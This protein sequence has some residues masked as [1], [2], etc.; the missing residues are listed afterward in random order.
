VASEARHRFGRITR[1]CANP[2]AP[3]PPKRQLALTPGTNL[4]ANS[5]EKNINMKNNTITNWAALLLTFSGMAASP[6]TVSAQPSRY[7]NNTDYGAEAGAVY[8]ATSGAYAAL[9]VTGSLGRYSG[10]GITLSATYN[11]GNG[12]HAVMVSNQAAAALYDSVAT[13]SG[14]SQAYGIFATGTASLYL[15]TVT[16]S[17]GAGNFN[18]GISL[19]YGSNLTARD[20][21]VT[22]SAGTGNYTLN[23]RGGGTFDIDGGDI[24]STSRGI[25]LNGTLLLSNFA[26][27]SMSVGIVSNLGS[28]SELDRVTIDAAG[29]GLQMYSGGTLL[30]RN[31]TISGS[32][33][34]LSFTGTGGSQVTFDHTD[35][36]GGAGAVQ[37]T[38]GNNRVTVSGGSINGP[39]ALR[40]DDT[41]GDNTVSLSGAVL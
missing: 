6:L 4:Y 21:H 23:L 2:V 8:T 26:I 25:D 32:T 13:S 36:A 11:N 28:R 22:T 38:N 14:A 7:V 41:S 31:S 40:A 24:H 3:L 15:R 17:A 9:Q 37:F 16:V 5:K 1:P 33:H 12:S 10:T 20:L 29:H 27:T 19:D 30:A 18:Y 39:D 34:G 35:L